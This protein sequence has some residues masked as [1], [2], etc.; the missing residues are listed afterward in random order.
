[1]PII[2]N[3]RKAH[4]HHDGKTADP[5]SYGKAEAAVIVHPFGGQFTEK[6]YIEWRARQHAEEREREEEEREREESGASC[7]VR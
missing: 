7:W 6:E 2:P 1:M 4:R 3:R 5:A